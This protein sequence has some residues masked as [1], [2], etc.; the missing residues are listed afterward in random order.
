LQVRFPAVAGI[1]VS[2]RVL[3]HIHVFKTGREEI[4]QITANQRHIDFGNEGF[5][6]QESLGK[7]IGQHYFSQFSVGFGYR[8]VFEI[9]EI[10]AHI[11]LDIIHHR[12]IGCKLQVF[13]VGDYACNRIVL[14][15]TAD[16]LY[17]L[18]YISTFESRICIMVELVLPGCTYCT[19]YGFDITSALLS[20]L[21]V[22]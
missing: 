14:G 20:S 7:R 1:D 17:S 19:S 3:V 9:I 16:D 6:A 21:M 2:A 8:S 13:I 11:V 4:Q 18:T 22:K 15:C 10:T 5:F 12:F